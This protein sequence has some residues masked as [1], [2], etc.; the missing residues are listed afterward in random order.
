M[1]EGSV[2][3][4]GILRRSHFAATYVPTTRQILVFGGSRYFCGEYFHD[5]LT[6]A[7]PDAAPGPADEPPQPA[8]PEY[9]ALRLPE[10]SGVPWREEH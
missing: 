3:G 4:G 6:I 10:F 2:K 8:G 1:L 7:L 9:I 5:L